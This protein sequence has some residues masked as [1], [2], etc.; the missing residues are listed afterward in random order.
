MRAE[1]GRQHE[2]RVGGS[3]SRMLTLRVALANQG[4]LLR[5][6]VGA[7]R[8]H[9]ERL[10]RGGSARARPAGAAARRRQ[11]R[12]RGGRGEGDGDGAGEGGGKGGG[13]DGGEETKARWSCCEGTAEG[14][15]TSLHQRRRLAA[16][17]CAPNCG[18]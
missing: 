11:R 13:K 17:D 2:G 8:H 6:L 18:D 5:T 3:T 14:E 10:W 15:A 12:R 9:P 4:E 1:P 7:P 16:L